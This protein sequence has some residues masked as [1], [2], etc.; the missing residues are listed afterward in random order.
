M[1]LREHSE[2]EAGSVSCFQWSETWGGLLFARRVGFFSAPPQD[3]YVLRRETRKNRR[4][5]NHQTL[6]N[7]Q[8][9]Q[10]RHTSR[11]HVRVVAG[12]A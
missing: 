10:H 6:V 8:S 12:T 3:F 7:G 9:E 11:T 4:F 1:P 2:W 5:R